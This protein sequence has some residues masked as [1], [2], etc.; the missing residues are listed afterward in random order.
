MVLLAF[1]LLWLVGEGLRRG[2]AGWE[3]LA[4][5]LAF[6]APAFARPLAMNLALP[7]M[8]LVLGL[9][10]AVLWRRVSR[11]ASPVAA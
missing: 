3:K 4:I 5:L 10:F 11:P 6:A 8:P 7:V 9:L 1:P 2:F